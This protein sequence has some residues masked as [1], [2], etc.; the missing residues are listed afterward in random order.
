MSRNLAVRVARRT[1]VVQGWSDPLQRVV[2]LDSLSHSVDSQRAIR[3]MSRETLD[4]SSMVSRITAKDVLRRRGDKSGSA[5]IV[6]A[7]CSR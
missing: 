5:I 3:I 1:H 2:E 6:M 7:L 4:D